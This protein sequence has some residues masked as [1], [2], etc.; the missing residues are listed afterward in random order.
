MMNEE[1][2]NKSA[3]LAEFV[4]ST[5]INPLEVMA[6]CSMLI[7]AASKHSISVGIEMAQLEEALRS[8][9]EAIIKDIK[10]SQNAGSCH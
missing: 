10:G 1:H 6:L 5:G 8:F 3:A 7:V 2:I 9:I 4:L